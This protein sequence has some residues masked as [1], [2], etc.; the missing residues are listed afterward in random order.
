[1]SIAVNYYLTVE[2][3]NVTRDGREFAGQWLL[4]ATIM[5]SDTRSKTCVRWGDAT[6][7]GGRRRRRLSPPPR[8]CNTASYH[9]SKSETDRGVLLTDEW[10][11]Q[12][13]TS[14]KPDNRRLSI[15]SPVS[16]ICSILR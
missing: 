14:S 11:N 7:C 2:G 16:P 15:S 4:N 5:Q 13:S 6:T 8:R 12:V 10:S 3:T 1:M 9:T